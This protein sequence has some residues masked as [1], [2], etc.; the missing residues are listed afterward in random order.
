MYYMYVYIDID[1]YMCISM[2][3]GHCYIL[4]GVPNPIPT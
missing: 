2:Y 1:T 4:Q 3:T